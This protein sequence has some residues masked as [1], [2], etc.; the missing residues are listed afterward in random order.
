[1]IKGTNCQVEVWNARNSNNRHIPS[2]TLEL[3]MY[4]RY[5]VAVSPTCVLTCVY[6]HVSTYIQCMIYMYLLM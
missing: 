5:A 6:L 2:S 3:C 1:M 4:M